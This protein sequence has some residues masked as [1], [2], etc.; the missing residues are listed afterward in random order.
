MA[1]D[2]YAA[3]EYEADGDTDIFSIDFNY[4]SKNF[5]EVYL[6]GDETENFSFDTDTQVR[7]DKTPEEG[8][9]VRIQRNT[10]LERDVDFTNT[11]FLNSSILDRDSLRMLHI[12][13]EAYDEMVNLMKKGDE[14]NWD[15]EGLVM[16][17]LG[18]PKEPT[19]AM[20]MESAEDYLDDTKQTRDEAKDA[21]DKAEQWAEEDEDTEVEDDKYSA[22]HHANKAENSANDAQDEANRAT[23]EADEA[24]DARDK[25]EQWAEED[26]D[27]EVEDDKYSAYHWAQ[28]AIHKASNLDL[29]SSDLSFTADD[30]KEGFIKVDDLKISKKGDVNNIWLTKDSPTEAVE[31]DIWFSGNDKYYIYDGDSWTKQNYSQE[32]GLEWNQTKDK[33]RRIDDAENLSV[34]DAHTD[35]YKTGSDFD[36]VYPWS[37]IE[38]VN[39][40]DDGTVNARYGDPEYTTDG[41]NG[42]V[43][44]E[45]PK[46][47]WKY[48][49]VTINGDK[50]YRWLISDSNLDGY[51]LHPNFIVD[52]VEKDYVYLSA[53]EG[54]VN[55]DDL[56][57]SIADVQPSTDSDVSEGTIVDFRNYAQSRGSGWQL[58]TYW[59]THAIQLLYLIEYGDFNSQEQIGRGY[60]DYDSGSDN[61]S[62]DTGATYG[63]D[64][65]GFPNDGEKASSYRGIEN[66]WGNIWIWI[67]G[68][69]IDEYDAYVTNYN[70][71][72]DKFTDN[73]ELLDSVLS[74][75]DTFIKDI[76]GADS[77][78]ADEGEGSSS[79]YL[80]DNWWIDSGERVPRF[81]GDWYASSQAGAFCWLL[82]HSSGNSSR[83]A[84]SRLLFRNP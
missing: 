77:F 83:G 15:A 58:Q 45:I 20:N 43:M 27:T 19:D 7:L 29:D 2:F 18:Y 24:K 50:I 32:L 28:K 76:T 14:N 81:G 10:P 40:A 72:S 38:R 9:I 26:E 35:G 55:S 49:E 51:E 5:I 63:N 57:Q 82:K 71:E 70:F 48:E 80:T 73:Y 44:V 41:S 25:A 60:V 56:L 37:E 13:Q 64:S 1:Q 62:K 8:T 22:K 68:L 11:S 67:D 61:E 84:G 34:V 23:S 17:D 78:L 47:Y 30:V 31:G 52:D 53:F 46:F 66:F 39:L 33:Y 4:L 36:N 69:N 74:T 75:D 65:Y 79:T 21:R 59:A 6:D 42:Q 54:N 12:T 16:K 3:V